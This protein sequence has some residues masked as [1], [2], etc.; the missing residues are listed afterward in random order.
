[1]KVEGAC[2]GRRGDQCGGVSIGQEETKKVNFIYIYTHTL[3]N[4]K[5]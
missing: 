3:T 2:L 1:M 5:N 4:K